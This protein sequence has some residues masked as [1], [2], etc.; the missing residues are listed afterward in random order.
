MAIETS[1]DRINFKLKNTF[2]Y[3]FVEDMKLVGFVAEL[4]SKPNYWDG[5]D[6]VDLAGAHLPFLVEDFVAAVA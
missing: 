2:I 4:Q 5:F 6:L 3:F 1:F